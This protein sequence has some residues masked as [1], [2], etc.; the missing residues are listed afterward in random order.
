MDLCE[1][2]G[3]EAYIAGNVGSG[4]PEE[5]MDWEE[6]LTFDGDKRNGQPSK[7]KRP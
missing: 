4:T 3:A 5:M 2:L 7:A 6:Y 1:L